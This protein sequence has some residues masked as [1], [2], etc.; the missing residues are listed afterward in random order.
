MSV[1]EPALRLDKWLWY[2]RFCKS[3][4]LATK[5]C[6]SGHV[7]VNREPVHKANCEIKPGD[8]L[9]FRLGKRVRVIEVVALGQRRGPAAEAQALYTDLAPLPPRAAADTAQTRIITSGRRPMGS[10]R[11]TKRE[12]RKIDQLIESGRD[13][14]DG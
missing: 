4:S 6:K 2:A 7:R 3:R 10:G 14:G 13:S 11:P 9:T 12:R 5:L 8:V 1:A